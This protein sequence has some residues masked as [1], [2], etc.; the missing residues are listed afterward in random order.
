MERFWA[1]PAYALHPFRRMV[2]KNRRDGSPFLPMALHYLQPFSRRIVLGSPIGFFGKALRRFEGQRK[3]VP[4]HIFPTPLDVEWRLRDIGASAISDHDPLY[5]PL[6]DD[7]R[8]RWTQP[9]T[10]PIDELMEANLRSCHGEDAKEKRNLAIKEK[11][12]WNEIS[13]G[14]RRKIIEG[15]RKRWRWRRDL[16]MLMEE[17]SGNQ[18]PW[19]AVRVTGHRGCGESHRPFSL[20]P[21][22]L[23]SGV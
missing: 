18:L 10:Y 1:M 23:A 3:E 12:P 20:P 2:S 8:A 7:G 6:D 15:W 11:T 19:E 13:T 5:R 9:A 16:D 4:V 14:E 22:L 21:S 17:V